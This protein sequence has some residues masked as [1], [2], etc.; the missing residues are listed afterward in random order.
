MLLK[1][2]V[3]ENVFG[4]DSKKVNE[5]T[6]KGLFEIEEK[7]GE[8]FIKARG[9]IGDP[10]KDIKIKVSFIVNAEMT[11]ERPPEESDDE[12]DDA[13]S[14][15]PV[16]NFNFGTRKTTIRKP[17]AGPAKPAAKKAQKATKARQK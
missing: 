17:P 11:L 5:W 2:D 16:M 13:S 15:A 8:Q 12:D 10:G 1:T 3:L 4:V 9:Y 7:N 14:G 6:K